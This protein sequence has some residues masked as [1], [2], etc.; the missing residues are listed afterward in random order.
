MVW[1]LSTLQE[2]LRKRWGFTQSDLS[3]KD[4]INFDP[5]PFEKALVESNKSDKDDTPTE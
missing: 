1:A 4:E 5:E 2:K 3:V